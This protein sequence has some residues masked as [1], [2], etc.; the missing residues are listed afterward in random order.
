MSAATDKV[1]VR[2]PALHCLY[3]EIPLHGHLYIL[4]NTKWY[5]IAKTFSDQVVAD[6]E[7]MPPSA[8]QMPL[9]NGSDEAAYNQM[10]S[11]SLAGSCCMDRKLISQGGG[12]SKIEF[13]DIYTADKKLVH[14]KKYGQSAVLSHLFF[15]GVVSAELFSGDQEFRAKLNDELPLGHKLAN[16]NDRPVTSHFEVVYAIISNIAG[17]LDIPFFSK[18]SLRTA[19]RRLANLGYEVSLNKIE[20]V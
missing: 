10:A 14:V 13:C 5:E 4:N 12:R 7:A 19:R 8:I 1:A 3:A 17:P 6:F 2:W 16:P 11:Q 9:C 20:S 15:Q 18:V